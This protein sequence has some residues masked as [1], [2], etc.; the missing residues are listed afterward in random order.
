MTDCCAN[1]GCE[2]EAI[3][4]RQERTLWIV[5]W[6]NAV[7]FIVEIATAVFAGS[8]ALTG[9]SI[10]MMGDALA[11]GTSIYVVRCGIRAK[12][13]AARFKGAIIVIMAIVIL[14]SAVYRTIFREVPDADIMGG[15]GLLA[16]LMNSLCLYLLTRHRDEDVN[17]ASVWECSRNDIIANVSVLVA[18][19]LVL[20]TK[21]PW[22]DL[23]VGFGLAALFLRSAKN[24]FSNASSSLGQ[25]QL[26]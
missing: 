25:D 11:Y 5:L 14:A 15:I 23:I 24:I 4:K 1:K 21:S 26:A 6:I 13:N 19:G 9:D 3:A 22:P 20:V 16:L 7:M 2:L 17:M 18:A 8:L 10:D 12:A